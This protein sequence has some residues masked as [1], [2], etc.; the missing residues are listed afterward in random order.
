MRKAYLFSLIVIIATFIIGV[1]LYPTLPDELAS[2]WNA[3]GE[4]DGYLPKFWGLFMMPLITLGIFALLAAIPTI[5]PLKKNL[6]KSRKYYDGLIV[7]MVLFMS[8]IHA[9]IIVNSMGLILPIFSMLIPA[10]TIL[11]YFIGMMMKNLKRNWF[12]GVKTPWTL[13]SAPW[14][15]TRRA[16]KR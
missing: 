8:Y 1:W 5:D 14:R 6:E 7:L 3:A 13:S 9:I 2:H 11:F 12:V 4:I 16:R 15:W 10:F